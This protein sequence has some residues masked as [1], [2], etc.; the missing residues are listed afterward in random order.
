MAGHGKLNR[1]SREF[2][3]PQL[4]E[5]NHIWVGTQR[6]LDGFNERV[7]ARL[8]RLRNH[9]DVNGSGDFQF[10]RLLDREGGHFERLV[11]NHR[12]QN[13]LQRGRLSRR[14]AAS[15]QVQAARPAAHDADFP[16]LLRQIAEVG[17]LRLSFA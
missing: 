4:S 15:D 14:D 7:R 11:P 13:P 8:S 5:D 17:D 2:P 12:V 9:R 6:R 16:D 3:V 10:D 1:V